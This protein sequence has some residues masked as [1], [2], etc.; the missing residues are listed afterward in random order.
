MQF[1]CMIWI[2]VIEI[3]RGWFFPIYWHHCYWWGAV[4][5]WLNYLKLAV[6]LW[7]F[8]TQISSE[9]LCWSVFGFIHLTSHLPC[10]V[11]WF[12]L[13]YA[14]IANIILS[15][16]NDCNLVIMKAGVWSK[17]LFVCFFYEFS[18]SKHKKNQW[19]KGKM[20]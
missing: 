8:S 11:P 18:F 10:C 15:F 1:G 6:V 9:V 14:F 12:P 5:S 20:K 19:I 2:R 4:V 13:L 3:F 7:G 16:L 17:F